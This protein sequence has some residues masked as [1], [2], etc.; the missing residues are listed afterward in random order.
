MG[1]LMSELEELWATLKDMS[2]ALAQAHAANRANSYI[3]ME[4]VR[5]LARSQ[6]DP[7]KY[8]AD[9]LERISARADYGEI[10]REAHPVIVEF[11]DAISQFFA[12]AGH[13][14]STP[15]KR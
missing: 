3:L 7:H 12:N 1:D 14:L 2:D 10:V 9:I 4:V 8:L 13:D 15:E 6:P 5:D 11:R